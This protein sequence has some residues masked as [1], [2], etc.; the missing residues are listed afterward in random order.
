MVFCDCG[1]VHG[2]NE[3]NMVK[4][5]RFLLPKPSLPHQSINH[6]K[7]KHHIKNI[8]PKWAFP[9]WTQKSVQLY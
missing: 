5:C 1:V 4:N 6:P 2:E 8:A 3:A 7:Q 9:T